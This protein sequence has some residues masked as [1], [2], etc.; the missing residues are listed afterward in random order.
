MLQLDFLGQ[1]LTWFQV[2]SGLKISLRKCEIIPVGEVD[3]IDLPVRVS[4]WVGLS[5]LLIWVSL[6][7]PRIMT[8]LNG[9]MLQMVEKRLAGW[10]KK[11]LSKGVKEV[12]I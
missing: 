12:I 1:V 5:L 2:V 11:Y 7:E 9:M 3:N 4:N 8:F 10:H 6:R